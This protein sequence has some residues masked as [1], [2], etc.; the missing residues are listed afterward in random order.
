MPDYLVDI[1]MLIC[2]LWAVVPEHVLENR[3]LRL[4]M[5]ES[6]LGMSLMPLG[7]DSGKI[8]ALCHQANR[9]NE[10]RH[11]PPHRHGTARPGHPVRYS[12]LVPSIMLLVRYF[13]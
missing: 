8:L 10:F 3:R 7:H 6:V 4:E 12:T 11:Q 1:I 13:H 2:R 5:L 9:A